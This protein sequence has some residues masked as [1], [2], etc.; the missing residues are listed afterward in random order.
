V[1]DPE[2]Y[3]VL[4]TYCDGRVPS[5]IAETIARR[6]PHLD[7][8]RVVPGSADLPGLVAEFVDAGATKFVVMPLGEAGDWDGELGRL[9][10]ALLPLET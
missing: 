10:E 3:G 2:H 4:L 5:R 1:P 7:P 9:A 6:R 8:R